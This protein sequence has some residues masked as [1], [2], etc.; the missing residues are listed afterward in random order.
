LV[1]TSGTYFFTGS[2]ALN[3]QTKIST[4]NNGA[5]SV[6]LVFTC[7]TGNNVRACNSPGESGGK[8]TSNGNANIVLRAPV[9]G[10][11]R[12]VSIFADRNNTADI[13]LNGGSSLSTGAIYAPKSRL[14]FGGSGN[15]VVVQGQLVMA[16]LTLNGSATITSTFDP[17]KL[18]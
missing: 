7:R 12:G 4:A 17:T 5:D 3:G 1:L 13:T 18:P 9:A 15:T 6:T 2:L 14:F 10:P 8:L 16:S 11:L